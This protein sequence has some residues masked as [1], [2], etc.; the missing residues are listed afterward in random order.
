MWFMKLWVLIFSCATKY[1][2]A[3]LWKL[4]PVDLR[5]YLDCLNV[6]FRFHVGEDRS[7]YANF[8]INGSCGLTTCLSIFVRDTDFYTLGRVT[9]FSILGVGAIY[10]FVRCSDGARVVS[11]VGTLSIRFRILASFNKALFVTLPCSKLG[12]VVA[13]RF[14]LNRDYVYISLLQN[15]F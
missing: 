14:G 6:L 5:L 9:G 8:P 11:K 15:I 4:V 3:W 7:F 12:T 1:W 2:A 13:G 10:C